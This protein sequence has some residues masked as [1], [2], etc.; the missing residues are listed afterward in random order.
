MWNVAGSPTATSGCAEVPIPG[1][2]GTTYRVTDG[3]RRECA[4]TARDRH[5]ERIDPAV[6][7]SNTVTAIAAAAPTATTSTTIAGSGK[8]GTVLTSTLP[9]WN[10]SAGVASSRQWLRNGTPVS[11]AVDPTFTVRPGDVGATITLRVT[12]SLTGHTDG[13]S[14][15]NGVVGATGDAPT[16]STAPTLSGSGKV[17]T[18]L[19]A[20]P[21]VWNV[22]GVSNAVQ[23]LRDGQPITD[24][25]GTTYD[26]VA[27]D[28]SRSLTVRYTGTSSGRALPPR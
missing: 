28:V 8:V 24:A 15:S 21:P 18:S 9:T 3:G 2:T 13:S 20:T 27:G 6:T 14:T 23:W 16:A 1:A 10:P 12:G 26:V 11:G 22:S 5:C 19:Q 7:T 17:G 4:V 25:A